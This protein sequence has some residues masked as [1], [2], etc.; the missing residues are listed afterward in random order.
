MGQSHLAVLLLLAI[1]VIANAATPADNVSHFPQSSGVLLHPTSLPG[2]H[3][4][5]DLGSEAYRFVDFL[6]SAK[7]SLWQTLPIGPTGYGDCPYQ[8]LSSCA[9][10]PLLVS[11]DALVTDGLLPP[12]ELSDIPSFPKDHVL[13]GAVIE[14]KNRLLRSSFRHFRKNASAGQQADFKRFVE[15]NSSWLEDYS[16]FKAISDNHG[17]ATWST[18]EPGLARRDPA[19]LQQWQ[20]RLGEEIVEQKYFQ[21]LFFSQWRRLKSYANARGVRIV[22]DI[23]MFVA[24]NSADV[25]ANPHLFE[26]DRNG[27]PTF[28][29]GVPPD[30]FSAD[31]QLWGNPIYRWAAHATDGYRWWIRRFRTMLDLSDIIRLDHFRGFDACWAVPASD[32][33]AVNGRWVSVPGDD[34][35]RT[36]REVLG[37]LPIIVEDLGIITPDVVALKNRY[38][39]PGIKVL[40]FSFDSEATC[41][42]LPHYF[43]THSV[44][45]TGTHDTDTTRGWFEKASDEERERVL[46]YIGGDGQDIAW[47]MIRIAQ[48]SAANIAI[49]PVCD[50]LNLGSEARMNWPGVAQGNWSWR[51]T[52]EQLETKISARLRELCET[53]GRV[54]KSIST[55]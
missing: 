50:L 35:F 47:D 54:P 26:L 9:G 15:A 53:Y 31:G 28:V 46:R 25:W 7:Q 2:R 19:M 10:N 22:G 52:E 55:Q 12:A 20:E 29:A 37:K 38:D 49:V 21:Y 5:G 39:F 32:R 44:V 17:G 6:A 14:Y 16:V 4:I 23:P 3:G 48:G 43:P 11:P 36:L 18:W 33:T 34:L 1:A 42:D 13:F 24:Y 30:T 8:C 51:F 45:Y 40:Q 41:I 27:H